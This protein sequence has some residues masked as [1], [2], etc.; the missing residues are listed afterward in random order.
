MT[1]SKGDLLH[2]PN[3][4][5]CLGIVV[6]VNPGFNLYHVKWFATGLTIA[7]S[8]DDVDLVLLAKADK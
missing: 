6:H 7:Y 5:G 1:F 3:L 2:W 4:P 8:S